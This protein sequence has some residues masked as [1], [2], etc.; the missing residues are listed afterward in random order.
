MT[1]KQKIEK[2]AKETD[3]KLEKYVCD[4]ITDNYE[5]DEDIKAFLKDLQQNGCVSGMVSDLIYYTDTHEFYNDY[6]DEIDEL[7]DEMEES[8]GEPFKIKGDVRN[9]L[10]WFAFEE[11]AERI[12]GELSI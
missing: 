3:S 12:A 1:T 4:Y 10:A 2:I 9:W 5:T 6:A 7:K 11:T 8:I